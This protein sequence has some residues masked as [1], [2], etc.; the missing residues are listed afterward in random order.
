MIAHGV[1]ES[2]QTTTPIAARTTAVAS[3]TAHTF[4]AMSS[5]SVGTREDAQV[6]LSPGWR[7]TS[8]GS[9]VTNSPKN[10]VL[11]K[12]NGATAAACSVPVAHGT[13]NGDLAV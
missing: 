11:V 1:C 12:V 2:I 3:H 4:T 13:I 10:G 9:Y 8:S 6:I 5:L 7:R